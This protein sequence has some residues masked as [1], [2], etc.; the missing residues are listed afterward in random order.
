MQ[1]NLDADHH[2]LGIC[3]ARKCLEPYYV[4]ILCY[5]SFSFKVYCILQFC[6]STVALKYG[7]LSP[8]HMKISFS[9]IQEVVK[10]PLEFVRRLSIKVQ[11]Q[12]P[13]KAVYFLLFC[14]MHAHTHAHIFYIKCIHLLNWE[15]GWRCD[16]VID[17][18]S[19]CALS[20]PNLTY[21]I[22]HLSTHAPP[23]CV[24]IKVGMPTSASTSVSEM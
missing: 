22:L 12:R 9:P 11:H 7:Y 8:T 2:V 18:Y 3:S 15:L 4:V 16:K 24:E 14:K 21:P 13:G 1:K 23:L 5:S 10:L 19:G 20:L 17:I 6:F